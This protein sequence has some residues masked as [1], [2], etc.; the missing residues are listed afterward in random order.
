MSNKASAELLD[1]LHGVVAEKLKA[2]IMSGEATAADFGAAIK[3]L[4]DNG[5]EADPLK[6]PAVT[7]L[8]DSMPDFNDDGEAIHPLN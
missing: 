3:F 5:V 2:R 6:S 4:K 1:A 7:S 8:A